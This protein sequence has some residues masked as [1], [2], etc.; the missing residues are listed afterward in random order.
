MKK[1]NIKIGSWMIEPDGSMLHENPYYC[2]EGFELN[3]CN[4]I[5]HMAC[6]NW[7]DIKEFIRAFFA[8]CR[9][10]G[11]TFVEIRSDFTF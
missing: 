3:G 11:L 1:E 7:V 8:A 9:R 6:K 5:T 4:W 2:I 10:R